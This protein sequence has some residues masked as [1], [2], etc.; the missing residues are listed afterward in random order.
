M[1]RILLVLAVAALMAATMALGGPAWA[2][3]Q[4]DHHNCAGAFTSSVA[5]GGA[6]GQFASQTAPNGIL[7]FD[8]ANCGENGTPNT[9]PPS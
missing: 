7:S 5:P 6:V 4:G 8:Q 2:A 1:K 9:A 3:V